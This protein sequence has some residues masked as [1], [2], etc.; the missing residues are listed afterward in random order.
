[1]LAAGV[2]KI[3]DYAAG[4]NHGGQ[5]SRRSR[6]VKRSEGARLQEKSM[7]YACVIA[8][9][10]D[11]LTGRA[12]AE[13]NR[14]AG[15]GIIDGCELTAAEQKSMLGSGASVVSPDDLAAGIDPVNI[16]QRRARESDG[17]E[18]ACAQQESV[19]HTVRTRVPAHDVSRRSDSC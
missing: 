3:A 8:A 10:T 15:I 13:S 17:A 16:R 9:N 5:G 6:H 11:D 19:L 2:E 12:Y 18:L 1:M 4:R 7:Q 14:E